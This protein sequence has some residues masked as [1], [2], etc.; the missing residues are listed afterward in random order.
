MVEQA[1]LG[2]T[3]SQNPEGRFFYGIPHL[4][5]LGKGLQS[6]VFTNNLVTD[7]NFSRTLLDLKIGPASVG[8]NH[9]YVLI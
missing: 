3:L 4:H 7:G 9:E 2:L 8:I 1:G 6:F 5:I